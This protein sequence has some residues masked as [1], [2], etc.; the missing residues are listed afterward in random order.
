MNVIK[1]MVLVVLTTTMGFGV[2]VP[3]HEAHVK[4]TGEEPLN[5]IPMNVP[6]RP[7]L[8]QSG[9]QIGTTW[10]DAQANGN[11]GQRIAVDDSD[12]IHVN[13]MFCEGEYPGVPRFCKWNFRFPDGSWYGDA[14]AAPSISGYTQ[15]DVMQADAGDAKRTLNAW[16]YGGNGYTSIDLGSGWGSWPGDTGSPHVANHIWPFVACASNNNIVMATGNSETGQDW[17]HFYYTTDEG[18][19]WNHLFDFDSCTCLSQFVRA[20]RNSAKVV[21][22]W[23]QSIAVEQ[24]GFLISQMACDI[25]YMLSTDNG[26]NWGPQTNATNFIPLGAMVNNDSTPWAY[27]DVNAIFDNNDNLHFAFGANLGYVFNDTVYYADHAKIFHWD[28]VTNEIHVVSSPSIHYTDPDGWWLDVLGDP[29]PSAHTEAWRLPACGAQLV[30][31]P[32]NNDLY[33]VWTGTADTTDYS[34]HGWFNSEIYGAKSVDGGVTW[35]NYVNFTNTPTPGAAAGDCADEDYMSAHPFVVNDT[36]WIT[37]IYDVEA[38]FPLQEGTSVWMDNPVM[39]WGIPTADFGVEEHETDTPARLSFTLYPNPVTNRSTISY[40][41]PM[42]S[43]VSIK[44]FSADGR[45]IRTVEQAHRAAGLYTKEL[46]TNELANGTYF[47]MLETNEAKE[48][49]SLVVVH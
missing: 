41:L 6:S 7:Y 34:E 35:S 8:L 9:E 29:G 47:L 42:A 49:R 40:T 23:T 5:I 1:W 37:Y 3:N 28:E 26:V 44:L 18:V 38:G 14:T 25:H 39:V 36:V 13:W 48:S 17:H 30:L 15:L 16:H 12:Q 11:F 45:L 4:I 46:R 31:D 22:V 2:V 10:Y 43:D 32:A 21:H 20:S 33:C 19:T 27:A 24:T